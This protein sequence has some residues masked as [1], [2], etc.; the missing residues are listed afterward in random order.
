MRALIAAAV[1][2]ALAASPAFAQRISDDTN[3]KILK[4]KAQALRMTP[5]AFKKLAEEK[6]AP[7]DKNSLSS[8]YGG[9]VGCGSISIG[10]QLVERT[11]KGDINIIILGDVVNVGNRCLY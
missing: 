3:V 9:Q 11:L 8:L 6:G 5:E 4:S 1:G 2:V 10:N 7:T